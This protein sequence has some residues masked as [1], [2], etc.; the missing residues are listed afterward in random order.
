M[1]VYNYCFRGDM[2]DIHVCDDT[3]MIKMISATRSVSVFYTT[4]ADRLG[5]ARNTAAVIMSPLFYDDKHA[6]LKALFLNVIAHVISQVE[7]RATLD[8]DVGSENI[9]LKRSKILVNLLYQ[10]NPFT[11]Q[12]YYKWYKTISLTI[13]KL[14]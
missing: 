9:A 1:H 14:K 12:M 10:H 13:Q 2:Q 8:D 6:D 3:Q 5:Q 7:E 4:N 11:I